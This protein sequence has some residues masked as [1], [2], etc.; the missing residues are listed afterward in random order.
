M[1]ESISLKLTLGGFNVEDDDKPR[2]CPLHGTGCLSV[3]G[4]EARIEALEK[5]AKRVVM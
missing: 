3:K 5:L 4:L 2:P 1:Q